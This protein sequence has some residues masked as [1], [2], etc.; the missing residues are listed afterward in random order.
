MAFDQLGLGRLGLTV[1]ASSARF[2]A[3]QLPDSLFAHDVL[4]TGSGSVQREHF[5]LLQRDAVRY[6]RI[7]H[8]AD[9]KLTAGSGRTHNPAV[10]MPEAGDGP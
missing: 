10:V 5:D 8:Y 2:Q 6:R 7:R 4:R 3:Q 1:I 9:V